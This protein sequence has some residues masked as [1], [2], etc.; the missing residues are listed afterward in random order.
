MGRVKLISTVTESDAE[1]AARFERDTA[2]LRPVL[3]RGARRLTRNEADAEDLLQDALMHAFMGFR[4]FEPGTNLNAWLFRIMHNR[5]ISNH[6]MR[7]RRPAE[8]AV[9]SVADLD[10][11]AAMMRSAPS[12]EATAMEVLPDAD[13][14]AALNQ[15]PEGFR[16][17]LYYADVQGLTYAETARVMG[18]PV[19]T[20]MSRVFRAR[21][22]LRDTLAGVARERG[23]GGVQLEQVSA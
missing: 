7:Q 21:A 22:Q 8:H 15:L 23:V 20:V 18:T 6:R 14:K 19:G 3:M 4:R 16:T 9:G 11:P 13:I 2:P 12:A 17:A 10:L 1:L 5:W